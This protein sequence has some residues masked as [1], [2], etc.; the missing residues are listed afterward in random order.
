MKKMFLLF[1]F[2]LLTGLMSFAQDIDH[3]SN[4]NKGFDPYLYLNLNAGRNLIY[5][6]FRST[7][8]DLGKIGKQTG[9]TSGFLAGFQFTPVFGLRGSVNGGTFKSRV[10]ENP[11]YHFKAQ[12]HYLGYYLEPTIDFTNLFNYN[13]DRRFFFYGF[14]GLGVVNMYTVLFNYTIATETTVFKTGKGPS[15][16]APVTALPYGVGTKFKFDDNW[17]AT[18]EASSIYG[19]NKNNGDKLDGKV[20][21]EHRDWLANFTIGINYDFKNGT[22]L[23][24]MAVDYCDKIKYVV[25]PNPLEMHGD[26][27]VITIN[28]IVPERYM[29]KKAAILITPEL[30]YNGGTYLLNSFT[31]KGEEVTGDGIAIPFKTGGTF[32]LKQTIPYMQ[33]M[34]VSELMT[35]SILYKPSTGAVDASATAQLIRS[36]DKYVDVDPC[37]IADGV[38]ITPLWI[39]HD[40]NLLFASDK[41][42]VEQIESKEATIYFIFKVNTFKINWDLAL[43]SKSKVELDAF[44]SFIN[45]GW[46]IKSIEVEGYSSPEGRAI[47]NQKLSELRAAS[48]K[49]YVINEFTKMGANKNATDFQKD[50]RG[51]TIN[52]MGHGGDWN[53]FMKAVQASNLKEKDSLLNILNN[54]PDADKR[55]QAIKKMKKTYRVLVVDILPPLRRTNIRVNSLI[56]DK[57]N[58]QILSD[59]TSNP[60]S[61]N[62]EELLYATTLTKDSKIQLTIYQ[63]TLRLHN[64][65]WRAYNNAGAIELE[66][67]NLTEASGY[68]NKANSLSP[69]NVIIIN[70][71]GALEASKGNIKAAAALF[72]QAQNLGANE[73]YNRGIPLIGKARYNDA[74]SAFN[75]NNC[76][77]NLGLA[78][79]LAG[80]STAAIATLKCAPAAADTYYLLAIAGARTN[81]TGLLYESLMKSIKMES[82]FKIKA[83]NDR[84]F[85]RFFNTPEFQ[86][87]VK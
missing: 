52:T 51:V 10:D 40:E 58:D 36:K 49:D 9:F 22:N 24:R 1:V 21:G 5:G 16:W 30:K 63:T 37:K 12:T 71:L 85:I 73:N 76:R 75:G 38:I 68:L 57:S 83:A 53:G 39:K 25:S 82:S 8:V 65:D 19:L 29:L 41:R 79:L 56:P 31:L 43:N 54:E 33:G 84:E 20:Q 6:D 86:A 7:P 11:F 48:G 23:K 14:T 67:G 32:T 78:Q 61:L 60:E 26:S 81:D 74:I 4:Q 27:I 2:V 46:R 77:H 42:V 13:P 66:N 55:D 69:Q 50:L 28:G 15:N 59:A 18:F 3:N 47:D 35:N 62:N 72:Q 70:N 34:N 44:Y 87:I 17:G 64:G 45:K 80:N